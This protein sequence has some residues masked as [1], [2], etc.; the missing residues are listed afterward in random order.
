MSLRAVLAT[1]CI[2]PGPEIYIVVVDFILVLMGFIIKY[3]KLG[4]FCCGRLWSSAEGGHWTERSLRSK[5]SEGSG[6]SKSGA[7]EQP[8]SADTKWLPGDR[9]INSQNYINELIIDKL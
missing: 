1:S 5:R 4:E 7:L 9:P 8:T 2:K 6:W 3:G